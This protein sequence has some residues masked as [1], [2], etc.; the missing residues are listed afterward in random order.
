M[1]VEITHQ[2]GKNVEIFQEKGGQYANNS[3]RFQ[4]WNFKNCCLNYDGVSPTQGEG[5]QLLNGETAKDCGIS[6]GRFT[7][8]EMVM[9][10]LKRS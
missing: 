8:R 9:K 1:L 7:I 4:S 2:K 10:K 3:E 5:S 6:V